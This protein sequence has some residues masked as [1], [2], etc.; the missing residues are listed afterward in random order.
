MRRTLQVVLDDGDDHHHDLI[1]GSAV[2]G[3]P[4]DTVE[5]AGEESLQLKRPS[6][7]LTRAAYFPFVQTFDPF[8][9][10]RLWATQKAINR[11]KPTNQ[12]IQECIWFI[13]LD[14]LC[15]LCASNSMEDD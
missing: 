15:V 4:N 13:I 12:S 8:Q 11:S 9:I 5:L 2:V 6:H 14:V 1:K 7:T 10:R 3:P